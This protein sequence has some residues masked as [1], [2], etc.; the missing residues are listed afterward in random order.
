[1]TWLGNPA[2][3]RRLDAEADALLQFAR[4]SVV[5]E[6]FGYLDA[7]GVVDPERPAELWITCRMTHAFS[8]GSLLGRAGDGLLADHGVA[9]LRG[10]FADAEHG[11]WFSSVG[12]QGPVDDTKA[13]YAH[14]F[15]ILASSS[16]T[17]AGR[18]GASELLADALAVSDRHFWR[19]DEDAVVESWDRAFAELEDYRGI[20][21]N[22][23]TVEA[24]LAAA[25]VT[26][27]RLWLDRAVRIL[28]KALHQFSRAQQW[29][30]PEH[31]TADWQV[32]L[33]YNADEPAHPFRPYGATVGHWLE[34]ARLALHARAALQAL[35]EQPEDWMLE[36]AVASVDAAIAEGWDVDGA[37]G[38]VYTVDFD[39]KP[40]V[41]E[42]MHWVLCEALGAVAALHA[43]TGE[44]RYDQW[45]RRWWD[46]ADRFL[47]ERPGAWRHELD[48]ENRLS[49]VTWP[50]KPDIYHALQTVLIARLPLTPVLAPALA[51]GL[52]EG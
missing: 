28:R 41:H 14:A 29:R 50:G 44:D 43:A 48:R 11:G 42:R 16:A 37:P 30:L 8:L 3:A 22:M 39:G 51:A 52:L 24:Y 19:E 18:E 47:I 1:M 9:S 35:G 36:V 4:G 45:Y 49:T 27:E 20:N 7:D 13:A 46:Y 21:A 23:H 32:L 17:A 15:V 40:V 31:F 5:P 25:D 34:W 12:P 33:D 26:G 2:H 6:G 38:F 10:A